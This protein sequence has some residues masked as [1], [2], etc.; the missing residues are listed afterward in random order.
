MEEKN[1]FDIVLR[2]VAQGEIDPWNI[3]ITILADKFIQEIKSMYIP[4]LKYA[5]KVILVASILL[6]M[7]AESLKINE[8]EKK[9]NSRKRVFG[10]KRF[11]T[12][13]EIA[14]LLKEIVQEP[15]KIVQKIKKASG[16]KRNTTLKRK[17]SSYVDFKL[18]KGGIDDAM[19]FLE[20]ELKYIVGIITLSQLNY[21][22]KPNAFMALLFLNY[23]NKVNI[24]QERHFDEIYIEPIEDNSYT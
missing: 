18:V 8:E 11:Y 19:A 12:L 20:E 17:K 14:Y 13:E 15:V 23:D 2:L 22:Y 4:D 3:D 21:P 1:P 10:I 5:S 6:K 24:Y 16:E 7:K 9:K